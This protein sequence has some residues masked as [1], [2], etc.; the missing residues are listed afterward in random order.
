[1]AGE[2]WRKSL[3]VTVSPAWHRRES[4]MDEREER[5]IAAG[6]AARWSQGPYEGQVWPL[7]PDHP[8]P[9]GFY[10]EATGDRTH[11]QYVLHKSPTMAEQ[12]ESART[13]VEYRR[14]FEAQQRGQ[15]TRVPSPAR[16]DDLGAMLAELT[17]G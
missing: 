3:G 5:E 16:S 2:P 14:A 4:A 13:Q 17:G 1:M 9:E 10:V 15:S 7:S 8:V 12:A 6:I 11:R